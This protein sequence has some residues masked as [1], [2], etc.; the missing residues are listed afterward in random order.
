[1]S[2][3]PRTTIVQRII[4]S[5]KSTTTGND[6]VLTEG[7]STAGVTHLRAQIHLSEDTG[8]TSTVGYQTS[9][10]KKTWSSTTTFSGTQSGNG[11]TDP[12]SWSDVASA[13]AGKLYFRVVSETKNASA[14]DVVEMA[15]GKYMLERKS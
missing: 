3:G 7:E 4:F 5:A 12:S 11:T 14:T 8:A 10:D 6:N 13:F 2:C 15:M 9:N 1:M